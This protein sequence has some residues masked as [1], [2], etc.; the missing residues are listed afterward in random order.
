MVDL[1]PAGTNQQGEFALGNAKIELD[2]RT[3][4]TG[5]FELKRGKKEPG[6]PHLNS[7]QGYRLKSQICFGVVARTKKSI[8]ASATFGLFSTSSRMAL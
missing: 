8:A 7:I 5:R 2:I 1:R 3:L 4:G 6:E